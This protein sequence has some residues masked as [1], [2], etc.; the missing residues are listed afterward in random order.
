MSK[1]P[2]DE[3][4]YYSLTI[5]ICLISLLGNSFLVNTIRKKKQLHTPTFILL[6]NQAAS[7]IMLVT[8]DLLKYGCDQSI[9]TM[10]ENLAIQSAKFI[11]DIMNVLW[12]YSIQL[13]AYFVFLIAFERFGGLYLKNFQLNAKMICFVLW[14]SLLVLVFLYGKDANTMVM[15]G[16]DS[17]SECRDN[18]P[19]LEQYDLFNRLFSAQR[20]IIFGLLINLIPIILNVIFYTLV[21]YKLK[22]M[23]PVGN[24]TQLQIREINVRKLRTIKMLICIMCAFYLTWIPYLLHLIELI[25]SP[26]LKTLECLVQLKVKAFITY[27]MIA[28][29]PVIVCYFNDI[30]AKEASNMY[31]YYICGLPGFGD[32]ERTSTKN[33]KTT[34]V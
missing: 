13:S 6:A 4:I 5:S 23:E 34:S 7:D 27:S 29:N 12:I 14:P 18:F 16:K 32:K 22:Q 30:F 26:N 1:Y 2:S 24:R 21:I 15:Y 33:S 17:L 20:M 28:L 3:L 8:V 25:F 31:Y 10:P 9:W 11:C 19:W